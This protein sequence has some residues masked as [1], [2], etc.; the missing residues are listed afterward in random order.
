MINIFGNDITKEELLKRVGNI[1]QIAFIKPYEMK[2]G[3]ANGLKSFDVSTGNGLEFTIL[4]GKCL[5]ISN[6]RY[7]GANINFIAKPGIV[8]P[9]YFNPQG[10]EF[11]RFFQ[12]GMLYTCGLSN[13][14]A[15]CN[16]NGVDLNLHGRIGNTPAEKVNIDTFWRDDEYLMQIC[17]EM[18]EAGLFIENLVLRRV[19]STKLGSKS[20]KISN[21]VENQGFQEQPLMILFHINFGFPLLDVNSRILIP[22]KQITPRDSA[23]EI[24]IEEYNKL[25]LPQD[26]Y[27]EQL[28]YHELAADKGGITCV[29]VINDNLGIGVY[30]KYNINQ[31]PKLN[32]WKSMASGDYALGLSPANCNVEG[33]AKEREKGTLH[34]IKPFEKLNFDLEIG[35]VEGVQEIGSLEK[36]ITSFK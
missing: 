30:I 1:S 6:M 7:K 24:G 22:S 12:G 36:L 8:S 35:V 23:A 33:R 4:E 26:N 2:E 19:I 27:M 3:K 9:E 31:L 29:V 20:I 34:M 32:Q 17:G 18:R 13:T 10:L 28:F 5:D 21:E 11:L 15:P 14:G 25:S 16:D